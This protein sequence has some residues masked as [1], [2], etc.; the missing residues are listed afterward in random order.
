M[1]NFKLKSIRILENHSVLYE[2]VEILNIAT[3]EHVVKV[4]RPY[5]DDD[6]TDY[7]TYSVRSNR[8]PYHITKQLVIFTMLNSQIFFIN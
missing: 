8:C 5:F 1:T 7:T 2:V 6:L 3:L 4:T